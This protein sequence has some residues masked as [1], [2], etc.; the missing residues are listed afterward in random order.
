MP[1]RPRPDFWAGTHAH[2]KDTEVAMLR[3]RGRWYTSKVAPSFD[4]MIEAARDEIVDA[5]IAA[6]P[7]SKRVDAMIRDAAIGL[8]WM[9]SDRRMRA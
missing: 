4:E 1:R 5:R 3:K 7:L 9:P 6:T 8:G 2:R